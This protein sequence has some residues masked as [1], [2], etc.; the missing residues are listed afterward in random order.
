VLW[1]TADRVTKTDYGKSYA[2]AIPGAK[3]ETIES[4]GHFPHLEQPQAFAQAVLAF[5]ESHTRR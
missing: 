2:A 1:G 4:A 3:F 5:A